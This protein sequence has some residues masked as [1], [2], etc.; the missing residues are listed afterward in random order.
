MI[1]L[2]SPPFQVTIA[3]SLK[4]L[5]VIKFFDLVTFHIAIFTYKFYNH[6]LPTTFQS[7]F[8]K[9]AGVHNS[10]SF[11]GLFSFFFSFIKYN[12]I[13]FSVSGK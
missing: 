11:P 13:L 10:T 4:S 6:L 5:R 8:T 12:Y 1:I 9:V 3:Q 2:R 7:C